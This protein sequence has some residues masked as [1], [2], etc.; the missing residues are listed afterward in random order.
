MQPTEP[1]QQLR[2]VQEEGGLC[3]RRGTTAT[4]TSTALDPTGSPPYSCTTSPDAEWECCCG[5]DGVYHFD[6]SG[7]IGKCGR[8]AHFAGNRHHPS[9]CP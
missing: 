9:L 5:I 2:A 1:M 6:M 4:A 8:R 7:F 3:L